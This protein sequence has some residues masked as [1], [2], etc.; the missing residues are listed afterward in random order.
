MLSTEIELS[1]KNP[2]LSELILLVSEGKE[3]LISHHKK[4][5]AKLVPIPQKKKERKLGL[6]KGKIWMSDDFNEPLPDS[7]FN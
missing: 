4:P 1:K 2:K 6:H 3:V 5:V 7:F